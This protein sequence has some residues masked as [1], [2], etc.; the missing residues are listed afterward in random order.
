LDSEQTVQVRTGFF[1]LAVLVGIATVVLFL[2]QEGGLFTPRYTLFTDFDNIEGLTV[3]APVYLSGNNV[4][5]VSAIRFRAAGAE[6]A[7]RVEMDLDSSIQERIRTDSEA[8]IGTIG[9]L[10][11]KYVEVTI[12]SGGDAIAE[13][14]LVPSSEAASF[15]ALEAKGRELLDNLVGIS[16]S[17]DRILAQFDEEMG[18]ESIVQ[19][20]GGIRR[21]LRDVEKEDGLLHALIYDPAGGESITEMRETLR[22]TRSILAE[23][24]TGNGLLHSLVYAPE[25]ESPAL[26]SFADSARRL[27]SVLGKVDRGE[28]TLGLLVNDPSL[29]EDT[30]LLLSGARD[31]LLL[32]ALIEYVREEPQN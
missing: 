21:L 23:I 15:R 30:R 25:G 24:Q 18:G 3:N 31:S 32:K 19:T 8:I 27:D 4:G 28:G 26:D 10:G 9:L 13:S 14:G 5:R 16:A 2:S 20:L 6:K 17:T 29:Y 11:D 22:S 7:I 12:G 1:T